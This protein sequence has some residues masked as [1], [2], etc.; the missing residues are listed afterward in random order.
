MWVLLQIDVFFVG[1]LVARA[2]L[3]GSTS[4]LLILGNSHV[5][6]GQCFGKPKGH[7]SYVRTLVGPTI[8]LI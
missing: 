2:L 1:V 7:G 5:S 4:R 3:F 8:V 6:S